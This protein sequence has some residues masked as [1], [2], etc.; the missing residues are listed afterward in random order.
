MVSHHTPEPEDQ[1]PQ[2]RHVPAWV[3]R[4]ITDLIALALIVAALLALVLVGNA[5][6][7]VL[8]AAAGFVVGTYRVFLKK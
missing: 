3:Y 1:D 8:T 4:R 5:S 6:A 2:P 7:A